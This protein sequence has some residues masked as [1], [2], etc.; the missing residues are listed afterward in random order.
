MFIKQVFLLLLILIVFGTCSQKSECVI[1]IV[2]SV[3]PKRIL[4]GYK[5]DVVYTYD[6]YDSTYSHKTIRS[7]NQEILKPG[8]LIIIEILGK[9]PSNSHI[10]KKVVTPNS[11]E[12]KRYRLE[13]EGHKSDAADSDED[14]FLEEVVDNL[15]DIDSA[16]IPNTLDRKPEF[17]G[18]PDSLFTFLK[19]KSRFTLSSTRDTTATIEVFLRFIIGKEGQVHHP[20][21]LDDAPE[22][23]AEEAIRLV[24]EMP[25]WKAGLKDQVPVSTYMEITLF[26]NSS[27]DFKPDR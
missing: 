26:F 12:V 15:E 11:S 17:P 18:G 5:Q 10:A 24:S 19:R 16:Y 3:K 4:G 6:Y 13:S 21:L 25:K 14:V 9:D 2:E 1:G 20:K 27:D 7:G 8:D 23:F 22:L